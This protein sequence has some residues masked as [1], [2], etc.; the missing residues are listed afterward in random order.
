MSDMYEITGVSDHT[1][2]YSK[3]IYDVF[4]IGCSCKWDV[5]EGQLVGTSSRR[6]WNF[7]KGRCPFE[8]GQTWS[9]DDIKKAQMT[10]VISAAEEKRPPRPEAPVPT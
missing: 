4:D 9:E 10:G 7:P 8:I 1:R 2:C 5:V 6:N 3:S